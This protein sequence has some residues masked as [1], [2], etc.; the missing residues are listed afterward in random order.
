MRHKPSTASHCHCAQSYCLIHCYYKSLPLFQLS[1]ERD[2]RAWQRVAALPASTTR[3]TVPDLYDDHA[4][5]FRLY[6]E[7]D[8][9]LSLPVEYMAP[10]RAP[11]RTGILADN[12]LKYSTFLMLNLMKPDKLQVLRVFFNIVHFLFFLQKYHTDQ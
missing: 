2:Q 5:K 9:G 3:Y 7:T 1:V 6:T 11:R 8:Y 10:D 4:Y 12:V